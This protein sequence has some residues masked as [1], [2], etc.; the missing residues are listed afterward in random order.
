V[1]HGD[2]A[3]GGSV[4]YH[5]TAYGGRDDGLFVGAMPESPFFPTSRTVAESEFQFTLF[6]N[7]TGCLSSSSSNASA[8]VMSCLRSLPLPTIQSANVNSPFPGATGYPNF[9]FLPV[10]DGSFSPA[11]MY[12]LFST[13]RFVHVPVLVGGDT[14]EGDF[15]VPNASTQA[16]VDTFLVA[17]FP[18][19]TPT[20]LEAIHAAYPPM[21]RDLHAPYYGQASALYGNSTFMCGGLVV[22]KAADRWVGGK[23]WNYLYDITPPWAAGQG[24]GAVHTAEL[25]DIFGLWGGPLLP[26]INRYYMSFVRALDPNTYKHPDAPVFPTFGREAKRLVFRDPG[27]ASFVEPVPEDQSRGC[28][29]WI[30]LASVTEQ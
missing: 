3:G 27:N 21:P 14:N 6:A 25:G 10:I 12:S 15:F 4:A 29:L 22:S 5:L 16:E 7:S 17:N 2:S 13:G 18:H 23:S 30:S 19:L 28:K 24:W 20:N 8:S 1:I 11:H 9:Y 26:W